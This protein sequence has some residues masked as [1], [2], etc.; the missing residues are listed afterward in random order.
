MYLLQKKFVKPMVIR[1]KGLTYFF[2]QIA[3]FDK[4]MLLDKKITR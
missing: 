3:I 2:V 4:I 1:E